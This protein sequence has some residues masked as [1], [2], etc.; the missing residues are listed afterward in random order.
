MG[1]AAV[2]KQFKVEEKHSKRASRQAYGFKSRKT[3]R[4]T[5]CFMGEVAVKIIAEEKVEM[6]G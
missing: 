1:C 4:L 2:H 3:S 6:W 5:K